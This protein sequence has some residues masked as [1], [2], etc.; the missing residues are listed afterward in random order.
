MLLSISTGNIVITPIVKV[1]L[2]GFPDRVGE[3]EAVNDDLEINL[4]I[5]KENEN[6]QLLYFIDAFFVP[7]QLVECVIEKYGEQIGIKQENVWICASH[8][9]FAPALDNTKPL[10]GVFSEEYFEMVKTNLLQLT[11]KVLNIKFTSVK[12]VYYETESKL[13]VNRR[14]RL[15]R[16]TKHGFGLKTLMYPNY[17]GKVDKSLKAIKFISEGG[18]VQAIIW[19]YGCHPVHCVD[20]NNVSSDYVGAIRSRLRDQYETQGLTVGFFQGLAGNVKADI[21]AVT[22]TRNYDRLSYLFQYKPKYIN[23]PSRDYYNM[24]VDLLWHELKRVISGEATTININEITPTLS[25]INLDDV[26]SNNTGRYI[27][28]RMMVLAPDFIVL[29][30]SAEVVAEYKEVFNRIFP[31][32]NLMIATCMDNTDV[33][34]PTDKLVNEGGYEVEGFKKLF[35]VHGEFREMIVDKITGAVRKLKISNNNKPV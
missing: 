22:H 8:T 35:N 16:F 27:R 4:I 12:T 32:V 13:N 3:F 24:W 5:L 29:G 25:D 18:T 31:S 10:L 6:Y 11:D 2:A 15:L 14:K 30:I 1:P 23:F 7:R 33:Y 17:D 20:R 34:I 9:H 28:L 19:N 21:T 26:L